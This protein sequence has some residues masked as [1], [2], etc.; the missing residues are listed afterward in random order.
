LWLQS[1]VHRRY[2][3]VFVIAWELD[4]AMDPFDSTFSWARKVEVDAAAHNASTRFTFSHQIIKGAETI[5]MFS[6]ACTKCG[7]KS[8]FDLANQCVLK[9]GDLYAHSC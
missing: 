5:G 2:R 8:Q 1:V 4:I 6:Y 3:C 9:I 7:S